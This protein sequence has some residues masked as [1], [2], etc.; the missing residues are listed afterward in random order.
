M[1][2]PRP[3]SPFILR[4][5]DVHS[6][7]SKTVDYTLIEHQ[8]APAPA[9]FFSC[10]SGRVWVRHPRGTCYRGREFLHRVCTYQCGTYSRGR[11]VGREDSTLFD[12]KFCLRYGTVR[13][14]HPR[15]REHG[16]KFVAPSTSS[17]AS[18]FRC[19]E[20]CTAEGNCEHYHYFVIREP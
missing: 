6:G 9:P 20:F 17:N 7:C 2:I 10:R 5:Q 12:L 19:V 4:L 8:P 11:T 3:Y 15:P 13:T 1:L 16:A 14:S 18:F